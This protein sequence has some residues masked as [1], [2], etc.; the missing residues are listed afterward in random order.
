MGI[1]YISQAGIFLIDLVFGFYALAII[2]RFMLQQIRADFYNPVSQL[3]VKV[4][5]PPL[6][7][8]RKFV[9]GYLGIDWSSVILLILVEGTELCLVALLLIGSLP[10]LSGLFV[11]IIAHILQTVI[12]IYMFIILV[13]VIISWVNPGAYNPI[14]VIM[15]QLSEPLLRPARKL[16]PPAGGFDWSPLIVL[17][18]INLLLILLVAPLLDM[19]NYFAGFPGRFL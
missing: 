4:T 8:L 5:N 18:I 9:P 7:P 10:A 17:I 12:Y 16:I 19:G 11:L 3:L 13:Q 1:S 15:H 2:L 6:K 14:T